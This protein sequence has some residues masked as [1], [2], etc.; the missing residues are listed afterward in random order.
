M[1][2]GVYTPFLPNAPEAHSSCYWDPYLYSLGNVHYQSSHR[3]TQR[4]VKLQ[5]TTRVAPP[6]DVDQSNLQAFAVFRSQTIPV[7]KLSVSALSLAPSESFL[8]L[9]VLHC[10]VSENSSMKHFYLLRNPRWFLVALLNS[11]TNRV[12]YHF[13]F[14]FP[15]DQ[16]CT[17]T[18]KAARP[19]PPPVEPQHPILLNQLWFACL[20]LVSPSPRIAAEASTLLQLAQSRS[21]TNQI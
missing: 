9:C 10:L 19:K 2:H 3:S 7:T 14:S 8:C 13:F 6:S 5:R 20:V 12:L 4:S 15:V 18:F 1:K 21:E 16:W 11:G 17:F